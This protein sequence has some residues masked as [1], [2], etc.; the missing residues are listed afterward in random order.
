[1][2][3]LIAYWRK[4]NLELLLAG[5][6]L[7][8]INLPK[9]VS[10]YIIILSLGVIVNYAKKKISFQLN[11]F[12]LFF[13][14]LY[15]CY[16]VGVFWTMDQP[17]AFKYLENKLTFLIF[18]F[19]LSFKKNEPFQIAIIYKGLTLSV[20]ISFLIGLIVAIPCYI[21]QDS[22]PYCFLK[23]HLSQIIHPSYMSVYVVVA[24]YGTY[25][26]MKEKSINANLGIFLITVLVIY[27]FM[28]LSLAGVL[29]FV[30][31]VSVFFLIWVY[32]RIK[33]AYFLG[34]LIVSVGFILVGL[35][36][37]PFVKS[38]IGDA[39]KMI[40]EFSHSPEKFIE[41]LPEEPSS[42][43][44][45]LVLWTV[46]FEEIAKHPFG[47]G[48][49]NVDIYLSNNLIEKG[50]ASF[51]SKKYNP[52]NQFI[53]TQ[54]E[55][56]VIGLLLLVLIIM[57]GIYKGIVLKSGMIFLIFSSLLFNCLFE[58]MLQQQAGIIFYVFM[59]MVLMIFEN[60]NSKRNIQLK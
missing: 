4:Y 60:S 27:T 21:D 50:N 35:L 54:L 2:G 55:I 13:V 6:F 59:F 9:L 15:L 45:R 42:A 34:F 16:A 53:Q 33:L 32:K 20:I 48:T 37:A 58:S 40:A 18:P 10:L 49:G 39:Q 52:H 26:M 7:V 8:L 31:F 44:T 14:V 3:N 19:L 12:S 17:Q 28:L 24:L 46:S 1:M 5:L 56:G 47:V 36:Y 43:Q 41:N 22:F 23:S 51:A 38:D 11:S 29:F 30:L 25:L 57:G